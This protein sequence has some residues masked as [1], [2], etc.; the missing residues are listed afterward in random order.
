MAA[1]YDA[2]EEFITQLAD[3]DPHFVV[4]PHNL[5]EYE[6]IEDLPPPIETPDDLPDDIEEWLTYFPG[7]KPRI[8]GGDTYTALLIGLSIPFPKLVKS[9]SA[10]MRNKRFGLWMAYL[11]SEQPTS[12]GWLL[13]STS[14]MDAELLKKAISD[15]IENIP[16]GLRWKTISIGSQGPIPK[17]QQVKAL[18]I[19]VDELDVNMAKLLLTALYASKMGVGHIFPLHI[20]MRL[21]PEL[22]AVLHTK[23]QMNVDKL[24]ACQNTWTSGKLITIK[25]WEIKL[26]DDE[27]EALG[28][29]LQ[30][31]MMEL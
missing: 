13:F 22:D 3:E 14:T 11:Q 5:S 9:L 18:H 1:V 12:L 19:Y 26:L 25:T 17:E 6:S 8:S 4:F 20:R 31:A 7:A 21:V 29:S 27:S 10:W 24:Q 30:D 23:G 16:V 15:S 2:L 28:M